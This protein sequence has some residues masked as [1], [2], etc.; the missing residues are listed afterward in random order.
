MCVTLA[1]S[2]L[3]LQVEI[4]S[5]NIKDDRVLFF[6][7]LQNLITEINI[8]FL[9]KAVSLILTETITIVSN[10]VFCLK[11]IFG[12]KKGTEFILANVLTCLPSIFTIITYYYHHY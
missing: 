11:V 2:Y 3:Q 12:N 7:T 10:A 1:L 4:H 6:D 9:L 8:V 5:I